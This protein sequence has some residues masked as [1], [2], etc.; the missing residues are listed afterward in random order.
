MTMKTKREKLTIL[1][2]AA[3]FALAS[4]AFAAET[5]TEKKAGPMVHK[6]GPRMMAKER[7]SAKTVNL[8]LGLRDLW[9]GHIFWVR[10]EVLMTKAGNAAAA[11]VAGDQVVENAKAI[12][13]SISPVYGK[14]ASDKLF[15]LLAA[16]YGAVKEYMTAAY[17]GSKEGQDAAFEKLKKNAEEI[18]TF[19]NGANPKNW[20]RDV[21][22]S[23]LL[24]H[25]GHHVAQINQINAG[26]YA[27]EANTWE[28]M[29]G[30]IYTIAD[31][32]AGGIVKQF[33]KKF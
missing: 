27:A 18:A 23:A 14:E 5:A 24:A 11:K 10:N 13:G 17:G 6:P 20:P 4:A 25:G 21:L 19:L 7:P 2:A 8:R 26:D 22:L 32:L 30:H 3:F 15:G 29:K 31:V 12:A 1:L 28:A 33:P 16:H 9:L